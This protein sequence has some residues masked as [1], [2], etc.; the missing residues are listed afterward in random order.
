[1]KLDSV[2]LSEPNVL[3]LDYVAYQWKNEASSTAEEV[4]RIDQLMRE[5]LGFFRKGAKIRRPYTIPQE[6][7]T[8]A[9]TL[10]LRFTFKS[11][12][13]VAK[14]SLAIESP[15]LLKMSLDGKIV[16]GLS[17]KDRG[18]TTIFRPSVFHR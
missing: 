7:R 1:M 12:I 13:E 16:R 11:D 9:G 10:R 8:P 17:P 6:E 18:S 15:E 3:L 2:S 4:L 5:R 14:S